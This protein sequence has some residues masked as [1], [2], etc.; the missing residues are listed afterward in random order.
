MAASGLLFPACIRDALETP[1]NVCTESIRDIEHVV[2]LLQENRAFDHYF[3][4]M[5]GVRGFGD[6]FTVPMA[7]TESI[8]H[9]PG[10]DGVITP[11]HLDSSV[12][13]AQRVD[14]TPHSFYDAH[15]AWDHGRYTN[16]PVWKEPQSMG[17]YTE[18]ELPFQFA[19]A[20]A[21]TICD[22][23]FCSVHAGTNPNRLF[24]FTGTHDPLSVAGG[25]A[26]DNSFDTLGDPSEGYGWTT[27]AER[28]EAAGIS[29]IV[30]QDM[31][32]NFSDNPLAGFRSFR[33]AYADDPE[34]PLVRKGLSSTLRGASL[35]GMR[36]DVLAGRLP[37]VSWVVAPAAY[38][39]HPD[40]SSPVQG[41]YYVQQVLEALTADPNV[42]AK[43][44]LF[45][46][47]DENDGFFDHLPTPC[48][49]SRTDDGVLMGGSTVDDTGERFD[50]SLNRPFGGF[51]HGPGVR[52][53][54]WIVSPFSRGGWVCSETFDHTSILRFLEARFGVHEPNISPFRRAMCGD[55]CSAFDFVTP[56]DGLVPSLPSTSQAE[57]DA[58]RDAQEL[59][60]PVPLPGAAAPLP[61]QAPGTRPSRAL[62]YELDVRT[63]VDAATVT[64]RF[65]NT[66]RAGAVFHL[67]DRHALGQI[68]RRYAV[69]A[70][71]SW[72]EELTPVGP[73]GAY[74]YFVLGPNGFHRELAG[75]VGADEPSPEVV[76][77]Y[78]PSGERL[79]IRCQNPGTGTRRFVITEKAYTTDAP[80][81]V[82]LPAGGARDHWFDV[83]PA[84][85]WYDYE[86]TVEGEVAFLR[87]LAGRIENGEPSISDPAMGG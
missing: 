14:G 46:T 49:P 75:R 25:P 74:A 67:Y 57:A 11:Y 31:D 4:T 86:V 82:D 54:M 84:G 43:T 63:R 5:R 48:A 58:L 27:Y 72:S 23:Y 51:P 36:A 79:R 35:D 50:D 21:F 45:V 6:R 30:Y 69:E 13:N 66:G 22:A 81:V 41:A 34:S 53:P 3:G 52:V 44:A 56:N 16:W 65:V 61:T 68:P 10:P 87:R 78:D 71:K 80:L 60:A 47:F 59:L 33:A 76:T 20:E 24:A 12:G 8:F 18:Q 17:Y 83:A 55:L 32:D 2:I 42:F 15:F 37:S 38:S 1:A 40:P 7:A 73:G 29:W 64:L 62:P 26:I 85:R 70:G 77:G 19:L 39:E 9:Q 28:L